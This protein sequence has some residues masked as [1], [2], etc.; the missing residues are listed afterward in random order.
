MSMKISLIAVSALIATA[1]IP[2]PCFATPATPGG[3]FSGYLGASMLPDTEVTIREF[4]PVTEKHA[5]VQFDPG[6][7]L[8]ATGGYDFG[9]LR[10]EG[11]LAYKRGEITSVSERSFGT[12]YVNTD[13]HLRAFS[14]MM[15][16]FVDLHNDSPVTPYFGGGIGYA[17]VRLSG[18]RGVDAGTGAVNYNIFRADEDDVFAYQAGAGLEVELNRRLSFDLGYRYLGTS[19]ATLIGVWPNSTDLKLESHSAAVGLRLKF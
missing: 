11:E 2:A 8:G 7:N 19:R 10:L 17:T 14:L 6:S 12:R 16:T 5:L 9:F 18:T 13:G 15:N 4:N 3:Y 1:V